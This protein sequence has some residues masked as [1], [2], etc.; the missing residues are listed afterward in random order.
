MGRYPNSVYIK[1]G[2]RENARHSF[3]DPW[4]QG[5]LEMVVGSKNR[6]PPK[7]QGKTMWLAAQIEDKRE[8]LPSAADA[9]EEPG[10]LTLQ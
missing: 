10:E 8:S 2:V 1:Q 7:D 9:Q 4:S 3:L 6:H 5:L